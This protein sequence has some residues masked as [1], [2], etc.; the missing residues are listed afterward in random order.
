MSFVTLASMVSDSKPNDTNDV[1]TSTLPQRLFRHILGAKEHVLCRHRSDVLC[2]HLHQFFSDEVHPCKEV[3][4][5]VWPVLSRTFDKYQSDVR[6]ME[7]CCRTVRFMLRCVSQQVPELLRPL[8]GQNVQ[9]YTKYVH[10]CF[11]YVG[12]ILVDEYG[13]DPTCANGLLDMLQAFIEPTFKVLQEKDGLRNHPDTVDDFFRLCARFLQR[14]PVQFLACTAL[15]NILQCGL[16]ACT[17]DHKEANTSVMK[18]FYDLVN[19]GKSGSAQPDYEQ[20]RSLV[21]NILNEFGEQLVTNLLHACVF[22]LHSYMLG[23]VSDVIIELLEFDREATATWLAHGLDILPKQ[24]TGGI[25][26]ATAQQLSD[27]HASITR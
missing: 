5:E 8:V 14:S 18:F 12:S 16:I 13:S 27:V 9:I 1:N 17:L 4:L 15:V 23:D 11:L 22:C 7:R 20:R 19:A 3:I 2:T 21:R 10:S 6:I 26:S 25:M 24:N